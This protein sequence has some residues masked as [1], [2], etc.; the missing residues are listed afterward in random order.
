[1]VSIRSKMDIRPFYGETQCCA[2]KKTKQRCTNHAYYYNDSSVGQFV[3]G[4]HV[5]KHSKSVWHPLPTNPHKPELLKTHLIEHQQSIEVQAQLN[6]DQGQV[7]TVICYRMKMRHAVDQTQGYWNIFPNY[8]AGNRKD[9]L[10]MPSLSP[11]SMG[12]INHQQPGLPPAKNL[13]NLHQGDKA[14]PS[15]VNAQGQ[16]TPEFYQTQ[17]AMYQDPIP[18]RH[19]NT[20]SHHNV[21]RYS[22]WKLPSGAELHLS[23]IESRQIYCHFYQQFASQSKDFLRLQQLRRDGYNLQICGYDAYQP[24][25]SLDEHYLDPSRPFGHELVLYTMLTVLP[26][27]YP[28]IKH[29]TLPNL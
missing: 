17:L 9:G 16:P 22:V 15:E 21:P 1:M 14:F 3:C 18:H 13:E 6:R 19:K 29:R 28:W 4:V 7:G 26:L 5:P 24:T 25:H 12:P 11:M 27:E 8:R 10:G 20:S 2:I 23:Y